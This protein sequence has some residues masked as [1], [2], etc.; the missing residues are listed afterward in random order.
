MTSFVLHANQFPAVG[1][2]FFVSLPLDDN[3]V[4]HASEF[5]TKLSASMVFAEVKGLFFPYDAQ[6]LADNVGTAFDITISGGDGFMVV[7]GKTDNN[8]VEFDGAG[9]CNVFDANHPE[10]PD[11]CI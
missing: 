1:G 6:L 4:V 9:W 5:V 10:Q 2:N 7:S 3:P 11:P 8:D